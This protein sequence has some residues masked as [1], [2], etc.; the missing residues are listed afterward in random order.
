VHDRPIGC[1]SAIELLKLEPFVGTMRLSDIAWPQ[2]DRRDGGLRQIP[3]VGSIADADRGARQPDRL[4]KI[5]DATREAFAS[6]GIQRRMDGW[7]VDTYAEVLV[8]PSQIGKESLDLG[9]HHRR[10]FAGHDPAVDLDIAVLRDDIDLSPAPDHVDAAHGRTGERV[11]GGDARD[12]AIFDR[13][14]DRPHHP[15]RR[16]APRG[17]R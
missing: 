12:V 6:G 8:V 5:A 3:S 9:E 2:D 1:N 15:D 16:S 14:Q 11:G 10:I 13:I 4:Q 7:I 17:I